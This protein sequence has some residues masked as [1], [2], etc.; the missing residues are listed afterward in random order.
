M[1]LLPGHVQ[2]A[3]CGRWK[4]SSRVAALADRRSKPLLRVEHWRKV[5]P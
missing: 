4:R 1:L 3:R 2:D 5:Q